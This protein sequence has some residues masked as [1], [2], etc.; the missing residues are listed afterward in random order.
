M[1]DQGTGVPVA[2]QDRIFDR[3]ERLDA[4]AVRRAKGAGL[5]LYICK[6]IVEAHGGHIW[7]EPAPGGGAIFAFA[8][9]REWP[10]ELP[11]AVGFAG[12][13]NT[14]EEHT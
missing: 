12:L 14:P 2:E 5:G 1:Q 8:I 4:R 3:F 13:L 6:A 10:A 7:F 9:P 11:A